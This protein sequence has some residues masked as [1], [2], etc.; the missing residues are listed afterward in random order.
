MFRLFRAKILPL[1]DRARRK[2]RER[3]HFGKAGNYSLS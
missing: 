1:L 2:S 3:R